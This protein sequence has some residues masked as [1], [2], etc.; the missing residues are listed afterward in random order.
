MKILAQNAAI[1][2]RSGILKAHAKLAETNDF[3]GFEGFELSDESAQ[4]GPCVFETEGSLG[5]FEYVV[6]EGMSVNSQLDRL[7]RCRSDAPIM[8]L[9]LDGHHFRG[10]H[11]RRW[12]SGIG[13]LYLSLYLPKVTLKKLGLDHLNDGIHA[14]Y[15]I[16]ACLNETQTEELFNMPQTQ[17]RLQM[18]PC[19]AVF[20]SLR[21]L[22]LSPV[23]RYPNDIVMMIENRPHK[24]AG[25]LTEL[26]AGR[27]MIESV[28]F[29]IGLN[30]EH[31][32]QI[33]DSGL[34]A[35]C[36]HDFIPTISVGQCCCMVCDIIGRAYCRRQ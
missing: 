21:D 3:S 31:A 35:C 6:V 15:Q 23:L 1:I 33:T 13:N 30:V 36:I 14:D 34:S 5:A 27:D 26:T 20:D 17:M 2:E 29:G 25:C 28:R 12:I 16:G 22:G 19:K 4:G 8:A 10:Q 18:M 24:I 32:P 7:K 9:A 11:G